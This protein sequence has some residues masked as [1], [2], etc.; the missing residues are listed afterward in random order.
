MSHVATDVLFVESQVRR[1]V[2][3]RVTDLQV[4]VVNG[5][6]VL[7]GRAHTFYVKQL[8]QQAVFES[9]RLP[10][11]ANEIEVDGAR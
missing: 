5:G 1:R 4:E 8:A 11:A 9:S 6:I 2:W 7:Q 3:G 10:L